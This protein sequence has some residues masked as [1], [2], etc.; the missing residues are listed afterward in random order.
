MRSC[1]A[2]PYC[3][4]RA[5]T[6]PPGN[7]GTVFVDQSYWQGAIAAKPSATYRGYLLGGLCWFAIPFTFATTM[8]LGARALDLPVSKTEANRGLVPPALAVHLMGKGGAFLMTFQLF[9]VRGGWR[10]PSVIGS[11]VLQNH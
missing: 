6:A 9:M 2:L 4:G 5:F 11:H 7:F 3:G 8:G 10:A 1:G